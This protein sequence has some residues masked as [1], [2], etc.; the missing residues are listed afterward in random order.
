MAERSPTRQPT[1]AGFGRTT[2][3]NAAAYCVLVN[4]IQQVNVCMCR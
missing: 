4:S 3:L 1:L 2:A